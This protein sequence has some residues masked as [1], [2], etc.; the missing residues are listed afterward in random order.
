[1]K[2]D[3][4]KYSWRHEKQGCSDINDYIDDNSMIK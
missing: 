1:M 2:G 3:L 4:L